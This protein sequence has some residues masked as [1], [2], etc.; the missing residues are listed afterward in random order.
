M[1]T[2]AGPD[3]RLLIVGYPQLF[4]DFEDITNGGDSGIA[5][6]EQHALNELAAFVNAELAAAAEQ[7]PANV[8]YVDVS[9]ALAGHEI[10]TDE[11]WINDLDVSF[12]DLSHSN[13]SFH[14]TAEGQNAIAAIVQEHLEKGR[15]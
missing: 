13:G 12:S 6:N 7:S 4:P 10:G 1:R 14:P 15:P 9:D 11:P 5:P 2:D 3:A 8:E